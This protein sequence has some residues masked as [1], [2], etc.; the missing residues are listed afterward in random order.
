MP[1]D[2]PRS[3]FCLSCLRCGSRAV[4]LTTAGGSERD[5]YRCT[6]CGHQWRPPPVFVRPVRD[7]RRAQR[8][9][10]SPAVKINE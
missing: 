3:M 9:A 7:R 5:E 8:R 6:S 10:D 1:D 4:E 2:D